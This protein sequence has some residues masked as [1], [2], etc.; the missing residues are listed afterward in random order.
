MNSDYGYEYKLWNTPFSLAA[1]FQLFILYVSLNGET[2]NSPNCSPKV[3]NF[4]PP[5]KSHNNGLTNV[6]S[7]CSNHDKK[8]IKRQ[9]QWRN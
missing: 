3:Q 2:Y 4:K 8:M 6:V 9:L 7:K 5:M 1:I